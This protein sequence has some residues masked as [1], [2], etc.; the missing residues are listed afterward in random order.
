MHIFLTSLV[1]TPK[2]FNLSEED[3]KKIDRVLDMFEP[4]CV[5]VR[6][7]IYECYMFNKRVQEPGES[8]DHYITDVIKLA[9]HCEYGE[10]K[11]DLIRDKLVSGIRE[12]KHGKYNN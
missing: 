10:L 1:R 2:T 4:R 11:D 8:V 3:Q 7:I 5:P 9:E 6:N 12:D